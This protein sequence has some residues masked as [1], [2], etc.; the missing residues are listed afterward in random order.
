MGGY[1][2]Y[3]RKSVLKDL[4]TIPKKDIQRIMDRIGSLAV[5]PHPPGHKKLAGGEKY[6]IRQGLYRIVYS[7]QDAE[8]TIWIVKVGHRKDVYEKI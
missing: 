7:I 3:F 2:I 8:L 4:E 1:K 5:D 6:R